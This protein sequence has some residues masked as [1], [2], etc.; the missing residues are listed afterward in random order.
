ML[1]GVGEVVLT[2][3]DVGDAEV[4]VVGAGGE[5]I[6]GRAVAAE[7]REVFDVVRRFGLIAEDGVGEGY[8]F[9]SGD[10]VTEHEGLAGGGAGVGLVAGHFAHAGI[11]LPGSGELGCVGI[12]GGLG[13]GEVSVGKAFGEDVFGQLLVQVEAVRLTIM[14][15]PAEAEPLEAFVDG[16][17]GRLGVALQIGVIDAEDHRAAMAAGVQ[18][19]EDKR[20]GA[21]DVQIAC[22]RRRKPY[23]EHEIRV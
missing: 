11:R 3:H 14:L 21:A 4:D 19:V 20:A 18:P 5:V 1:E 7:E 6:G 15:V 16:L 2:A 13:G 22:R 8:G 10:A 23:S 9:A 12:L 17:E